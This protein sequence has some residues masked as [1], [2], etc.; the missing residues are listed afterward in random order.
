MANSEQVKD[1]FGP[2]L[3]LI[4]GR[5]RQ[6]LHN[7]FVELDIQVAEAEVV[8]RIYSKPERLRHLMEK[9]PAIKLLTESLG[10]ELD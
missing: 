8:R 3:P 6:L 10:L 1:D 5:L 9:N 2:L 7:D 4:I